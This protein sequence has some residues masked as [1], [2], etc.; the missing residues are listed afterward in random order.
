VLYF[1]LRA[2]CVFIA[3][4]IFRIKI[5]GRENIPTQGG[6]IIAGNHVSFLDPVV[7]GLACPR[8]LHYM[9]RHTL[10]RH[11]LFKLLISNLNAFPIRRGRA[12]LRALREAVRRVKRGGG[13]LV[14]PEGSRS[15][16]GQLNSGKAGVGFLAAQLGVPVI[17]AF[18]SGTEE[19]MPKGSKMI[20]PT[21][22]TV[23]FG[24]QIY[25]EKRM[26]HSDIAVSI[27]AHIR[28]LAC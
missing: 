10:F 3:K 20:K 13:L 25:I 27:M 21:R 7:F 16:N 24:K 11:P 14:F 23:R 18:V 12:D 5:F 15:N 2:S 4:T 17:P 9:A 28:R 19:A 6:F 8:R 1:V 22:L 26:S